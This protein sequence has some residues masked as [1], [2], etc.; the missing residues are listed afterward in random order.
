MNEFQKIIIKKIMLI[1]LSV[2]TTIAGII[3]MTETR[4]VNAII[5]IVL[6]FILYVYSMRLK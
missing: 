5:I 2:I 4:N 1:V 3:I 6:G